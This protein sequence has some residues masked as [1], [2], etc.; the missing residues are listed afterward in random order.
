MLL[1]EKIAPL[2]NLDHIPTCN[3]NRCCCKVGG[4]RAAALKAADGQ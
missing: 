2:N 3:I 1:V 4:G